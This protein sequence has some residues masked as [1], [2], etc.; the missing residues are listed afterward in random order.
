MNTRKKV[1]ATIVTAATLIVLCLALFACDNGVLGGDE[2]SDDARYTVVDGKQLYFTLE[3]RNPS[4]ETEISNGDSR[5]HA[6]ADGEL[7]ASWQIPCYGNTTYES[8]VKFFEERQDKI[9]FR[10][11]QRRF[12]MFHEAVLENGDVYNLENAYISA[13][14]SY[15]KCANFQTLFGEDENPGT[16]DDLKVLVIVYQ[17]WLY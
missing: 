10:L 12:Y 4:G 1:L 5:P 11:S 8:I 3:L 2:T 16:L 13:D 7:I 9:S 17:G 6:K 15:S 14:G